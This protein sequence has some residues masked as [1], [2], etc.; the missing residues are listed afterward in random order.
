M[1]APILCGD[2]TSSFVGVI[3]TDPVHVTYIVA[4]NKTAGVKADG[5]TALSDHAAKIGETAEASML[6]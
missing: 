6:L 2:A 3:A 4:G 1:P 5:R